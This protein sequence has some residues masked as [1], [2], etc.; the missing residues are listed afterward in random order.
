VE[1][2]SGFSSTFT[3]AVGTTDDDDKAAAEARDAV[4]ASSVFFGDLTGFAAS[5]MVSSCLTSTAAVEVAGSAVLEVAV[6]VPL[7]EDPSLVPAAVPVSPGDPSLVPVPAAAFELFRGFGVF[8]LPAVAET[9][10]L[11]SPPLEL[12]VGCRGLGC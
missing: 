2:S 4:M 10:R 7:P 1:S 8:A 9:G 5:S 6:V 12:D 3:S 11:D